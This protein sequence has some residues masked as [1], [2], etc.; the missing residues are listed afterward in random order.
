MEYI[1]MCLDSINKFFIDNSFGSVA[2]E[3]PC[4]KILDYYHTTVH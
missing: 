3:S 2:R 1:T 4:I